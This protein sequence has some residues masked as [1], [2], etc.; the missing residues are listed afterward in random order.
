MT[1]PA[2]ERKAPLGSR[3]PRQIM[4]DV[5]AQH[6]TDTTKR[7]PLWPK[8]EVR[9]TPITDMADLPATGRSVAKLCASWKA[10][11]ARGPVAA[12][13]GAEPAWRMAD[14]ILLKGRVGRR[15]F[16]ALWVQNP[17]GKMSLKLAY[18][19]GVGP[20]TAAGLREYLTVEKAAWIEG[21]D[22]IPLPRKKKETKT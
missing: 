5:R 1:L 16:S 2:W 19:H 3:T 6:A 21:F 12:A 17:Q 8:P 15:L 10:T 13:P 18:A 22:P 7:A 20:T 11:Y 4:D 9:A 14:S